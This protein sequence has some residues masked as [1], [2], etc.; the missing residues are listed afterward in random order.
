[1]TSGRPWLG[2]AA[3]TVGVGAAAA[4]LPAGSTPTGQVLAVGFGVFIAFFGILAVLASDRSPDY[5]GLVVVGLAMSIVPFLGSGYRAD[6][7]AALTCW[8]AGAIA[9]VL[10]GVGWLRSKAAGDRTATTAGDTAE[11]SDLSYRIGWA[12]FVAGVATVILGVAVA[13]TAVAAGIAAGL[14]GFVAVLAVW[15]LLAADPTLDFL[16][17]SVVGLGLLMSPWIGDFVGDRAAAIAWFAGAS[18]VALGVT[19][20]LRGERLGFSASVRSAAA[21]RYRMQFR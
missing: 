9:M 3:A 7:G 1:M 21:E 8:V 2:W 4:A 6:V 15:S 20:Y 17:L 14:G 5:W 19:G 16:M 11:R 12:A 18:T 10:G 13:E